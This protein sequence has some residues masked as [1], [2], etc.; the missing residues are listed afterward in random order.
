MESVFAVMDMFMIPGMQERS[1]MHLTAYILPTN[2]STICP[3]AIRVPTVIQI[4]KLR[5]N[6]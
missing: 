4:W 5:K 2:S 3:A 1:V 6:P